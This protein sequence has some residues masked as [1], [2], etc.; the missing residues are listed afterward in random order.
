[1]LMDLPPAVLHNLLFFLPQDLLS[2]LALT[3]FHFYEPCSK[4][5]YK[6]IVIQTLPV[7]RTLKSSARQRLDFVR[8]SVTTICG[9]TNLSVPREGHLKLVAAKVTTLCRSLAVNP[10]L[11]MHVNLVTVD[12]VFNEP[13][14]AALDQ[15]FHTLAQHENAVAKIYISDKSVRKRLRY[16][17]WAAK[18]PL[19]SLVIDNLSLLS[20]GYL[21]Q[22]PNLEELIIASTGP[23]T[24]LAPLVIPKLEKIKHLHIR[25]D[26]A[27]YAQATLA[28]FHLYQ[29]QPFVLRQ[30][31][32]F[33][34]VQTHETAS[35]GFPYLDLRQLENFQVSIGCNNQAC[36]QECLQTGLSRYL[37]ERLK[38][39]AIVQSSDPALSSH[40][41][42][43][44][45]DLVMFDFVRSILDEHSTLFSLSIRHLLPLDGIIED[46]YEGNYA[47]KVKLYTLILPKLLGLILRHV[48]NLV[49]PNFLASMACYEQPMNTFLWNGC[50]CA[51]CSVYLGKLDEYLLHHRY[52]NT[53]KKV[54]KDLQTTQMV[55]TMAEV[56]SDRLPYDPN[57]GDIF[58]FSRPPRASTWNFHDHKSSVPFLCLP[59]KTYEIAEMEDEKA[60]HKNE[61]RFFDA[62]QTANDCQFLRTEQF[63]PNY[64]ITASHYLD[65]LVRKMIGLNRGDAE[66]A[67]LDDVDFENDGWTSLHINK[68]VMNGIDYIFDHEINGTIFFTNLFDEVVAQS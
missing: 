2:L 43:E 25:D 68:M 40:K 51:H 5:L 33:N 52:Y 16:S 12:G 4:Q 29:Q 22:F 61:D 30:L 31:R 50:K 55:R 26:P 57:V 11:A 1:M 21:D 14:Y 53:Q 9:F 27:T 64:S 45:W 24:M 56:L 19:K 7:L 48:V 59:V 46:G 18:L 42:T 37:F 6:N 10:G 54:Y 23:T 17:S 66:A 35:H 41:N 65:D 44:K 49:L 63:Y 47:R 38:R 67:D 60:E 3:N 28:L 34:V 8:S 39:L 13:V 20:A 36:D 62:E 58:P 32:S 15:L